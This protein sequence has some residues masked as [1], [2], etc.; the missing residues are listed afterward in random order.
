MSAAVSRFLAGDGAKLRD[1]I[2]IWPEIWR[3]FI[4]IRWIWRNEVV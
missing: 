2:P 3:S 1:E 4:V